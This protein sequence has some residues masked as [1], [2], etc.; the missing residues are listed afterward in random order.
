M[1]GQERGLTISHDDDDMAGS[2]PAFR[3]DVLRPAHHTVD[4][5]ESSLGV[6]PRL[7]LVV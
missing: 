6:G 1:G 2:I 7:Q 5:L 4:S 3:R